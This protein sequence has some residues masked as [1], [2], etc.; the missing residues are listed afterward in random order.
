[1]II[2]QP[3]TIPIVVHAVMYELANGIVMSARLGCR[4][5]SPSSDDGVDHDGDDGRHRERLVGGAQV[6][7]A[8]LDQLA[9][10]AQADAHGDAREEQRERAGGAARDPEQVVVD[11]GGEHGGGA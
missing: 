2:I 8:P 7:P 11:G 5:L 6:G 9:A 4:K 3:P 1:M 10:H